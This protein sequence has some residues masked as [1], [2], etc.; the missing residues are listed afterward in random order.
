MELWRRLSQEALGRAAWEGM[1]GFKRGR[2]KGSWNRRGEDLWRGWIGQ[3]EVYSEF[4]NRT[5]R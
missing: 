1:A 5:K 3:V 2:I 4:K